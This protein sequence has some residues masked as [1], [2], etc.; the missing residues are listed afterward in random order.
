MF[1]QVTQ[2]DT[3]SRILDAAEQLFAEHGFDGTSIR[4]ITRAADV[5]VAAVHYHFGS[6]EAVLRGVTDRVA[7]PIS[8]RRAELLSDAIEAASPGAPSVE[9]LLDA[10]IRA[11][12]EV[13][14]DLQERGPRV[15]RFLGR[16]Y[17]DQ[18]GWIQAMAGEQYS[19]AVAFYPHLAAA[20]PHLPASEIAWRMSQV[21]AV[22]VNLF[23]TWPTTGIDRDAAEDLLNRLVTFLA[24]GM[25]A[26]APDAGGGRQTD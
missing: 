12:T 7:E 10:F 11:D 18:T 15:A 6:K 19:Q 21:V 9:M 20:A 16:T 24:A 1:E 25:R 26:P 17:G 2:L 13:L 8:A 22:I 3:R 23:A 4:E 5:N 14:L